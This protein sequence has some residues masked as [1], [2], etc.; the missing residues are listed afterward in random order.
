MR[1]ILAF[2]GGMVV[3]AVLAGLMAPY[4]GEETRKRIAR[5]ETPE[6]KLERLRREIEELEATFVQEDAGGD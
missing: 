2:V 6:E 1:K 4:P 5:R 3:G